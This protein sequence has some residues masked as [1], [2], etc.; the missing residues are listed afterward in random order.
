ML[1][2]QAQVPT[3]IWGFAALASTTCNLLC[4][5]KLSGFPCFS[6]LRMLHQWMCLSQAENHPAVRVFEKPV[7][8]LG[9]KTRGT[10]A[11]GAYH[12][13]GRLVQKCNDSEVVSDG[14]MMQSKLQK[15]A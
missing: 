11:F 15:V 14:T 2:H 8:A 5:R 4:D 9:R 7:E 3:I 6:R 12:L 13:V 1:L 10:L